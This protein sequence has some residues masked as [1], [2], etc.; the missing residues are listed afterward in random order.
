VTLALNIV[1]LLADGKPRSFEDI[2]DEL[3]TTR[4]KVRNS[5]VW[6]RNREMTDFSTMYTLTAKGRERSKFEPM[7]AK[8]A[9]ERFQESHLDDAPQLAS[10]KPSRK[11]TPA[12]SLQSQPALVQVWRIA[13]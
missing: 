13:Q 12:P 10:P 8:R 7:S 2:A 6:L 4:D 9:Q 3:N 11:P 1:K 5:M